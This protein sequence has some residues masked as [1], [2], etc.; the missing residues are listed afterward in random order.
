MDR[1]LVRS[2][3]E[4]EGIRLPAF[5]LNPV[6]EVLTQHESVRGFQSTQLPEA[7]LKSILTAARSAPTSSNLQAYSIIVVRDERRKRRISELSG[8][9]AFIC[10]SPVMLVFCADIYRLKYI[11]ER[12]GHSFKADTLEMFL[13]ASVDAALAM[14][15]ALVAAESLR[16][17]AV[18]VGSVRNHP[19]EMAEEL[20]LP[21]GVY[22]LVG[23]S[24]GYERKG[25]RRGGKPR[26][27]ERITVHEEQYSAAG[28]DEDLAAYDAEMISRRT[29]DGRRVSIAGEPE[30]AELDY[31]WCEHTARRCTRPETIAASSSLRENLR[32]VLE[33]RGFSLR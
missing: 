23:L 15:N 16:L 7:A 17:G 32:E 2:R 14:Q 25:V 9:Q 21:E 29:Y 33:R 19:A 18:P 8:N 3:L 6:I 1:K 24:V 11:T 4:L 10:D 22:A 20:G 13:L 28:L 26:L 5:A 12:Q 27:P 31:G 30:S